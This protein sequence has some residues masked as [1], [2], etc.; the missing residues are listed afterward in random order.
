MHVQCMLLAVAPNSIRNRE[1]RRIG[2]Y[3]FS[4][5]YPIGLNVLFTCTRASSNLGPIGAAVRVRTGAPGAGPKM[6]W[7]C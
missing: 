7:K 3:F 4:V 5:L 2:A 1:Q 6:T